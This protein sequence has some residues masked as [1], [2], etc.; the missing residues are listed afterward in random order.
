LRPGVLPLLLAQ[1]VSDGAA[2]DVQLRADVTL[3]S[4]QK[5]HLKEEGRMRVELWFWSAIRIS[6]E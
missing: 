2:Q 6:Q 4:G 5:T 1:I 3:T